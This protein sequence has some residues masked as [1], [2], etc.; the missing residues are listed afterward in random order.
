MSKGFEECV[1]GGEEGKSVGVKGT[2]GLGQEDP[3]MNPGFVTYWLCGH[4]YITPLSLSRYNDNQ[5]C[6]VDGKIR[7]NLCK[8]SGLMPGAE[9][10]G[11]G[12]TL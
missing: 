6:G 5:P 2:E 11:E 7:N 1:D 8:A 4:G 3:S 9:I 12:W 10:D